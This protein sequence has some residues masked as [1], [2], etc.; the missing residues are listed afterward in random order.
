[1]TNHEETFVITT[2]GAIDIVNVIAYEY[3]ARV[4][5]RYMRAG[6]ERRPSFDEFFAECYRYL[7][8]DM[9]PREAWECGYE[10]IADLFDY[11]EASGE[12]CD[13]EAIFNRN[14]AQTLN[15]FNNRR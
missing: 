6:I 2:N 8:M 13:E 4:K 11:N 5:R 12:A 15:M 1:M 9:L 3:Y 10:F 7:D 14:I